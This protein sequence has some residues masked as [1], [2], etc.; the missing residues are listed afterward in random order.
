MKKALKILGNKFLLTTIIFVVWM[1]YFDQ[2]DYFTMQQ[3]KKE[4]KAVKDNVD[5]LNAETAR[6]QKELSGLMAHSEELEK[7]ARENYHMKR[8]NEDVYIIERK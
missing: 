3:K 7:L 2:N 6:M 1:F 5:Y 8:D 4:Y